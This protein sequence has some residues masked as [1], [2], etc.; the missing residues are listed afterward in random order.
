MFR[1]T[2]TI[3][4]TLVLAGCSSLG[5]SFV[6]PS[7]KVDAR[8]TASAAAGGVKSVTASTAWW[9]A[10]NDTQLNALI[11]QG[12]TQNLTMAQAVERVVAARETVAASGIG[13]PSGSTTGS[14]TTSGSSLSSVVEATNNVSTSLNWEI[15]LFGGLAKKREA[16]QASIDAATEEA[17]SAR[18]ALIGDIATNY[19]EARGYQDRIHIAQTTLE[20]QN[21]TLALTRQQQE[22]GVATQLDVA[23]LTGDVASTAAS[24]PSLEISLAASVHRLGVLLGQEPSAFKAMFTRSAQI[25]RLSGTLRAGI[26]SDLMR[27]RPDIRQA[28]RILAQA[29]ANIGVAE[30]DPYP[31]LSLSGKIGRAHV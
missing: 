6:S 8:Y 30:A 25:P 19:I 21:Q 15:D 20:S 22:L 13:L 4:T 2:T 17:N 1:I 3:A 16:A 24:I 26:P 9:H 23:Q 31:S 29:T 12:L 7:I 5:P 28:E 10:F 14:S 11:E 18:L 27:D